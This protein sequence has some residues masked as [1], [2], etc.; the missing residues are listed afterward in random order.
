GTTSVGTGTLTVVATAANSITQT[1]TITQAAAAGTARFTAGG[2]V[3]TLTQSNDFTG[4]VSASNTGAN[5]IQITDVNA[6][7]LGTIGTANRSEE[8]RVGKEWSA[9]R[10]AADGTKTGKAG[11][12]VRTLGT[13]TTAMSGKS[14]P[15]NEGAEKTA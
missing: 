3:I 6:L 9:R 15:N 1:G 8:R 7:I 13:A 12:G 10:P 14:C 5:A 2:V 4:A 11:A